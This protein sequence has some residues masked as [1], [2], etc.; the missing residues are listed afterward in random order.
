M[1][2]FQGRAKTKKKE[3]KKPVEKPVETKE[4]KEKSND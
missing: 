3:I 4:V 2:T 1:P